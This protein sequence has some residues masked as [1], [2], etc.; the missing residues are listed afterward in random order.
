MATYDKDILEP[1]SVLF[2]Y[3]VLE[4]VGE[5]AGSYVYKAR[6]P[7]LPR[8]VA[9]KQLKPELTA[10]QS[11]LQRFLVEANVVAQLNHPNVVTIYDLKHDQDGRRHYIVTEYAPKGTLAD[12][13]DRSPNG[14]PVDEVLPIAIGI[15][16][17]LQAVHQMGVVHRDIKPSNV[18][19]CGAEEG[20]D[21]PK[22]SDF[23]IAKVSAIEGIDIPKSAGVCGSIPYMSPEQQEEEVKVDHR[24]DLYSLG[25][26]LYELLTGQVP[27]AG[28]PLEVLWAHMYLAPKPPRE[29][30]P[31][32]P[33]EVEQIVLRLLRKNPDERYPSA[34]DVEEALKA[35]VDGS[36]REERQR[37]LRALLKEGRGHLEEGRWEEAIQALRQ[38]DV[39]GPGDERVQEGLRQARDRR[40]LDRRYE[41]GVQHLEE[42]NW[43]DAQDYL[44][45]VIS[46]DPDYAG[47]RA[48]ELLQ[49]ATEKLGRARRQRDLVVQYQTGIGHFR[50]GQ[51]TRAIAELEEV[52]EQDPTFK[53]AAAH[54][55]EARAY[56][57]A[58]QLR[59]QA[60]HHVE[61]GEW[62]EAVDLYEEVRNL[63]PPHIDVSEELAHAQRK[64]FET[65]RERELAALYTEGMALLSAGKLEQAKASL[66]RIYERQPDYQDVAVRIREVETKIEQSQLFQRASECEAAADWEGAVQAYREILDIDRYNSRATRCL[67]RALKSAAR[68]ERKG[69]LDLA[70]KAQDWWGERHRRTRVALIALAGILIV[71]SCVGGALA[72]GVSLP[73][74]AVPAAAT[75][76][77]APAPISSPTPAATATR[78]PDPTITLVEPNRGVSFAGGE[79]VKLAWSWKR[80]LAEKELFEVRIR[81]KGEETFQPVS[82]TTFSYH[83]I[84]SSRLKQRGTYEWQ[85]AVVSRLGEEKGVSEIWSLEVR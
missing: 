57:R 60:L 53:D 74:F 38:A 34:A 2:G 25:V 23:G 52:V 68:G 43:E 10:D 72:A 16:S 42:E 36:L 35:V 11:A 32:I 5:G 70:W 31:E 65:R 19:L 66:I 26:L 84:H 21:I 78:T 54:L 4:F 56:V 77:L 29:L 14:L 30:N 62:K 45:R 47:G 37:R 75:R 51:W 3:R 8:L 1:G 18:L 27:F 13:L 33:Q 63:A 58:G 79:N 48:R 83:Y 46:Y 59:E 7:E 39:L 12:R 50:Q 17:G 24:S 40:D 73:G 55:Q 69:L 28:E 20:P 80:E 41:L 61:R 22:L 15:C 71:A 82:L 67:A 9:I 44:A 64:W 85:V 76:T 6:H 49:L 81:F